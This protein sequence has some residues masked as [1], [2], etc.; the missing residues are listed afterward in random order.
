MTPYTEREV[1]HKTI[2]V[3]RTHYHHHYRIISSTL[4][5]ACERFEGNTLLICRSW[6]FF[7]GNDFVRLTF[8]NVTTYV[9]TF[10]EHSKVA[11]PCLK[12]DVA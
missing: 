2:R 11:F 12:N 6:N 4:W 9:I 5:L 1:F 3:Y 10:R 8:L 7:V